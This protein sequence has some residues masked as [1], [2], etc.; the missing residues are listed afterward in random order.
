VRVYDYG[1]TETGLLY[2][3]M[4]FLMGQSLRRYVRT[5]GPL[6]PGEAVDIAL[7]VAEALRHAHEQGVIHRGSKKLKSATERARPMTWGELRG[8]YGRKQEQLLQSGKADD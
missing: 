2:L 3:V 4:E 8:N 7:A 6:N 1:Q 5:T